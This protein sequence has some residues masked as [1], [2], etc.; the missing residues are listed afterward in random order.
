MSHLLFTSATG[1]AIALLSSPVQA[2]AATPTATTC[3]SL[4]AAGLLTADPTARLDTVTWHDGEA[5]LATPS[6]FGPP[7]QIAAP[8]HCEV[9]GSLEHR[10]GQNGQTYAIRFHLRLPA[11]WNGRFFFQGGGGTNG[12][13]GDALG[14]L[15]DGKT[16]LDAGYAVVSQD[17]GHDNA[18]NTD[19]AFNGP[20]AFGFDPQARKNYGHTSLRIVADAAKGLIRTYYGRAPRYSYFVGCSKGGQEGMTFAQYYP[21]EF[22]GIIASAPGFALPRAALAE[23]W[24]VQAFGA[25]V[26]RDAAGKPDF[27]QLAASFPT[28]AAQRVRTAILSACDGDD[29]LVDGIVGDIYR[30]TDDKVMA[31]L[32]AATCINGATEDCLTSAQIQALS[33]VMAGPTNRSGQALYA[34]WYWPTGI[35][36]SG[37]RM[38]KIGDG[39][40]PALNVLLGGGALASIFQTPPLAIPGGPAGL[41]AYQMA[42]DFDRDAPAIYAVSPPYT[43]SAWSD[44]GSRSSDVSAFRAHGGR[45]IVAHGESDPVFSL[46]DTLAWFDAVNSANTGHAADFVRVFPVPGMCHCGGGPSTDNYD[47]FSALVAWV[48]QK[49]AP[50]SLLG[51]AGP[52]SPWPGRQRPICAY[53]LVARYDGH[54]D[55]EKAASFICEA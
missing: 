6:G 47:A 38:W 43:T 8:A 52:A 41:F 27:T 28:K 37:W 42:Y 9:T 33:R 45:M 53:P 19:P 24:D 39:P 3:T 55:P 44:I 16:A 14:R 35:A 4:T 48:E 12:D 15:S 25:L 10:T 2:T 30:C 21:D 18:T 20:A 31:K 29:G 34:G 32:Q 40:V 46:K 50:D 23:A 22:N 11:R 13:I 36:D 26:P 49:K 51:T 5:P 1:L 7:T 17:S 54:G